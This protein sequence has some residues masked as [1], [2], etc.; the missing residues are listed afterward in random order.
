MLFAILGNFKGSD[1]QIATIQARKIPPPTLVESR[2]GPSFLFLVV[3]V[4]DQ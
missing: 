2:E 1:R 3:A 4:V